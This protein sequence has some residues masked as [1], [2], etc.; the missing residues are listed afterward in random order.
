CAGRVI[1][2]LC[3]HDALPISSAY[4]P[5]W[6]SR[7]E[8]ETRLAAE[9]SVI[10]PAKTFSSAPGIC[11]SPGATPCPTNSACATEA[12]TSTDTKDAG[13]SEEHTSEL[14]SRENLVCR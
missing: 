2:P 5:K 10:P 12:S 9:P 6:R 11:V 8:D 7:I 4:E 3:L 14:Q 1:W 13:R